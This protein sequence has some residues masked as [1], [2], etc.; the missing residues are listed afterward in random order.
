MPSMLR[1][2]FAFFR[3]QRLKRHAELQLAVARIGVRRAVGGCHQSGL[4][5]VTR[6]LAQRLR[7]R[8]FDL[9]LAHIGQGV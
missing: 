4:D 9:R 8:Q 7:N 1:A 2:V 3:V 6:Q 5:S